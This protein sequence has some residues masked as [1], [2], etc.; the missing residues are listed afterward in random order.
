MGKSKSQRVRTIGKYEVFTR[1]VEG[2][3]P[4]DNKWVYVVKKN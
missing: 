2:V 1:V 3:K 4:V